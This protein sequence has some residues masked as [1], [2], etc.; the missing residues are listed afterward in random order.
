[1]TGKDVEYVPHFLDNKGSFSSF[2]SKL[3]ETQSEKFRT[4]LE[5]LFD[6]FMYMRKDNE[7]S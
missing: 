7:E 4:A 3:D 1:M 5:M 6:V 2:L